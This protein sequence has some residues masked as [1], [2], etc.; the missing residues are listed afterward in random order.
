MQSPG[1][2][3]YLNATLFFLTIY[4]LHH[5]DLKSRYPCK[6]L[7]LVTFLMAHYD[8]CL[9][10]KWR[11]CGPLTVKETWVFFASF[12]TFYKQRFILVECKIDSSVKTQSSMPFE[13]PAQVSLAA[14]TVSDGDIREDC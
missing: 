2:K 8:Q 13:L 5:F 9:T 3:A 10:L 6:W 12:S 1:S 11:L 14:H 7:N 4:F